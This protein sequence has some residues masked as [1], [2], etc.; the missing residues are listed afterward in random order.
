MS[1][2][3]TKHL[4]AVY[5]PD[6]TEPGVLDHRLSVREKHLKNIEGMIDSGTVSAYITSLFRDDSQ[7]S[8]RIRGSPFGTGAY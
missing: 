8:Y 4:F 1:S 2:S 7:Y 6:Y 3:S 5:A